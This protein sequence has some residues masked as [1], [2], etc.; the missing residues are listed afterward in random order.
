MFLAGAY[1][2]GPPKPVAQYSNDNFNS[3][4][5]C[6]PTCNLWGRDDIMTKS[7]RIQELQHVMC[8]LRKKKIECILQNIYL[9]K[10]PNRTIWGQTKRIVRGLAKILCGFFYLR[11]FTFW[12][13]IPLRST[14]AFHIFPSWQNTKQNTALH[15]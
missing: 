7:V 15:V 1:S 14:F 13:Q 5:C 8:P 9:L 2:P 4:C 12:V 11:Q 3:C 6:L 10:L